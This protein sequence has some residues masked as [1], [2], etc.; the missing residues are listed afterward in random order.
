MGTEVAAAKYAY[1]PLDATL[2]VRLLEV[3]PGQEE[4]DSS[5]LHR[6]TVDGKILYLTANLFS[7]LQRAR[8]FW[9]R[10]PLWLDAV[11]INQRDMLSSDHA[12]SNL[13]AG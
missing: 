1:R 8:S 11:C 13:P 2:I 4:D 6:I 3:S 9:D 7:I 5:D 12:E 10:H